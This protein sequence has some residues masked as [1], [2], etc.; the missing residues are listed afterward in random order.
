MGRS[1]AYGDKV[2]EAD[3]SPNNVPNIPCHGCRALRLLSLLLQKREK[4][5]MRRQAEECFRTSHQKWQTG[6]PQLFQE[7][8]PPHTARIHTLYAYTVTHTLEKELYNTS[9]VP[10][11][12]P[13]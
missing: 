12:K 2:E 13:N 11:H 10:F 9:A 3:R 8:S 4:N 5:G 6:P 7:Q 1:G